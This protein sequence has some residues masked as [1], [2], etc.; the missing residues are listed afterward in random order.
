[1]N[2]KVRLAGKILVICVGITILLQ[3]ISEILHGIRV[4]KFY[5]WEAIF[6]KKVDVFRWDFIH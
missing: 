2:V 4:I 5:A 1:M 3:M 6:K